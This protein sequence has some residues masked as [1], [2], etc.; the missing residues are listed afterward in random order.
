MAAPKQP[1]DHKISAAEADA[2]KTPFHFQGVDGETYELPYFDPSKAGLTFGFIRKNRTNETEVMYTLVERL[3][4]DEAIS[5]LDEMEQE[6]AGEVLKAWQ[7][8][9]G[10]ELPKS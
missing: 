6:Q 10:A 4:G 5:A 9:A 7:E 3:A 2:L 8:A 1:Q